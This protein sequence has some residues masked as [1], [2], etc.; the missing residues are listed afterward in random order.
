MKIQHLWMGLMLLAGGGIVGWCLHGRPASLTTASQSAEEADE[1][2]PHAEEED[3]E[4]PVHISHDEQG[5][6]VLTVTEETQKHIGLIVQPLKPC[7]MKQHVEAY[8]KLEEDPAKSYTL[9]SPVAGYLVATKETTWPRVGDAL[10]VGATIG[11][12]QPRL[13]AAEQFDLHTRLMQAQGDISELTAHLAAAKSSY[14]SKRRLNKNE[15]VV[16]E[17]SLEEAE[18]I[19]KADEAKLQTAKETVR[20]LEGAIGD[21]E[22]G[23]MPLKI[24]KKGKVTAIASQ[25]G[26]AVESGQL[27]VRVDDYSR[28]IARVSLP[29]GGAMNAEPTSAVIRLSDSDITYLAQIIGSVA[30]DSATQSGQTYLLAVD[31][32]KSFLTPGQFVQAIFELPG[33]SKSG[34][35]IPSSAIVHYAGLTFVYVKTGEEQFTRRE[36]NRDLPI[37][38]GW[39]SAF[40]A[41]ENQPVVTVGAGS[42]LSEELRAQIEAEAESGE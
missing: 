17:R 3:A 34:Q 41:S 18:S 19:V 33:D 13:S 20:L 24:E 27:L 7:Q 22:A 31:N 15:N 38:E 37:P 1:K 21:G 30:S 8:G 42:L 12:V 32:E 23:R 10:D 16:A 28:L 26:E 40:D 29:L 39:C 4:S 14:E 9:R 25:T 5:R 6:H 35:M 2:K 36:I 11:M